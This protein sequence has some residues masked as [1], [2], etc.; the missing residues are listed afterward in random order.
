MARCSDSQYLHPLDFCRDGTVSLAVL[1]G[2]ELE[3]A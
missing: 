2:G 1:V 3:A